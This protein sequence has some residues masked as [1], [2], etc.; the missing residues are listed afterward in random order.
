MASSLRYL[1]TE[2]DAFDCVFG[3]LS[4]GSHDSITYHMVKHCFQPFK[5]A[6]RTHLAASI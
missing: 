5:V 1:Q 6:E 3:Q 4:S 2:A